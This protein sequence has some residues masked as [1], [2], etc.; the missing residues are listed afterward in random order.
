[1]RITKGMISFALLLMVYLIV[2][3]GCTDVDDFEG[4]EATATAAESVEVTEDVEEPDEFVGMSNHATCESYEEQVEDGVCS[5]IIECDDADSC[6][7]WGAQTIKDMEEWF[8]ELTYSEAWDVDERDSEKQPDERA[9]YPVNGNSLDLSPT[10]ED[11]E[12]YAWL[13]ER[14][15]WII[16]SERRTMVSR[17]EVYEHADL[18]AYVIQDEDNL[19]QWIY[20]ANQTQATYET[21]RVMTDIHEFGHL[22]S[23]NSEQVDP[24]IEENSCK[25]HMLDEG[26]TYEDSYINSFY[27]QF[28]VDSNDENEM[29]YVTEYAMSSIY[30]DFA[31]SW[32]HFVMTARP[33]NRSIADQKILFFYQYD[34]L[35]MLKA[36]I[37]GRAASWMDRNV[38]FE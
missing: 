8:G 22:L 15:A 5:Y 3:T 4:E 19:E 16:P 1:M 31:E 23:L 18:M 12:Y 7:A 34:E 38:D 32:S 27:R 26:C 21:E 20:A 33:S 29:S 14:F 11:E 10:N 28:W 37:L 9:A 30:E 36:T 17:F 25:T 13:W 2:L 6:E 35:I 24:Y